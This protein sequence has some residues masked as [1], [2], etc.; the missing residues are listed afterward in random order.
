[1]N[2][3]NSSTDKIIEVK[4]LY[5][6]YRTGKENFTAL[7]GVSFDV[8][9]GEFV[10]LIGKSGSGKSTLMHI[11]GGLD[12]P[13]KGYVKVLSDN[14]TNYTSRQLAYFRN[15]TIGFVFQSFNLQPT[16]S[17]FENVRLPLLFSRNF[18]LQTNSVVEALEKVYMWD[19]SL[20][21]PSELSGGQR[22]RV[23]IARAIV[24]NPKI[25]LAD[26]PTGNLDSKTG[27]KVI[28]TLKNLNKINKVTV[29]IVTHDHSIASQCDRVLTLSDGKIISDIKNVK[30]S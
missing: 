9:S 28:E 18:N 15:E 16:L 11:I 22:Q 24:N 13:T 6:V 2:I 29:L 25:I 7:N 8:Y 1:M 23:A 12:R 4:D 26:E 27:E 14:I 20:N 5:K 19:K 17:A 10:A 21:K 3:V 30:V